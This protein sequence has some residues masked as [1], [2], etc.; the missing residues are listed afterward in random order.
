MLKF[1]K[2][3]FCKHKYKMYNNATLVFM[4]KPNGSIGGSRKSS[5][6]ARKYKVCG[7]CGKET[8]KF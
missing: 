5:V 2:Q 6:M 8:I 1:L 4:C 3:L 7:K